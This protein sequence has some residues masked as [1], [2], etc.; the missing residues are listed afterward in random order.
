MC[1]ES[2]KRADASRTT[3]DL[4]IGNNGLDNYALDNYAQA[5]TDLAMTTPFAIPE[6]AVIIGV[7]G[8]ALAGMLW[9]QPA[10]K[11]VT[12]RARRGRARRGG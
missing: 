10:P 4:G 12:V 1:T 5:T 7:I 8:T 11:R 6:L 2:F 9:K 3:T